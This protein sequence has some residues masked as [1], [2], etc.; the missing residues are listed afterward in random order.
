MYNY[1]SSYYTCSMEH[2]FIYYCLHIL[3]DIKMKI[4]RFK[5]VDKLMVAEV[6]HFILCDKKIQNYLW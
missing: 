3:E 2:T 4:N 6:L 5:L 1:R